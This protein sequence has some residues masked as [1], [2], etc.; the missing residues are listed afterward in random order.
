M[1]PRSTVPNNKPKMK[2]SSQ[3]R[4]YN[5]HFG[6]KE[7]M[8]NITNRYNLDVIQIQTLTTCGGG[9]GACGHGNDRKMENT[10]NK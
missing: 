9:G 6:S 4:N 7:N 5:N 2:Y 10:P 1:N 8:L 3:N